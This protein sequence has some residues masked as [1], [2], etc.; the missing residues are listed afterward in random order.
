MALLFGAHAGIALADARQKA[1]L[2]VAISSRDLIGQAKGILMERHGLTAEQAFAVLAQHS[3][4]NN[5]KLH[6]PMWW[7]VAPPARL[8]DEQDMARIRGAS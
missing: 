6:L 4:E 2:R 1:D 7:R 8:S 5:R 3:Q